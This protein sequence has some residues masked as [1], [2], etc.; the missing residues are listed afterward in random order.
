MRR[1][2]TL[3]LHSCPNN[4]GCCRYAKTCHV[5]LHTGA[6]IGE[7]GPLGRV[8]TRGEPGWEIIPELA[9]L[10]NEAVIDKPGKGSF[11]ATGL[12]PF[13][14][15]LSVLTVPWGAAAQVPN[16]GF[17]EYADLQLLLQTKGIKY[18][19]LAG[20]TTDVCVHTTMRDANDRGYECLLLEDCCAAT[21]PGNHAA[22]VKMIKMQV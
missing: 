16:S 3:R 7:A 14:T 8:L 11:Y 21:D 12:I 17:C 13:C 18:I 2:Y 15:V 19:A 22:A 9:P 4:S 10:D 5:T 6:A 1:F 20:V